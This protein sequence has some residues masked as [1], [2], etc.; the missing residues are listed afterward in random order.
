MRNCHPDEK[1]LIL[2]IFYNVPYLAACI[3]AYTYEAKKFNFWLNLGMSIFVYKKCT[4]VTMDCN[5]SQGI[6]PC[7][8][9][10]AGTS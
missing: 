1:A 4:R 3:H 8:R 10:E 7:M 9:N 2:L 5:K 6:F